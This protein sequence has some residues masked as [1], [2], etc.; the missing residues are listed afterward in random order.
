[1]SYPNLSRRCFLGVCG[2]LAMQHSIGYS[3]PE[4]K[5]VRAGVAVQDITPEPG[6]SIAGH[7]RD[8][9]ATHVHDALNVRCLVLD[10]GQSKLVLLQ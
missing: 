10:D 8:R 5:E 3:A 6:I 2:G 9:K 1:M 4:Q 7:M